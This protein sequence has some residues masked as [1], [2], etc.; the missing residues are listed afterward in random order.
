MMC[1]KVEAKVTHRCES[2]AERIYDAWLNPEKARH[3]LNAALTELGLAAEIRRIEIDARVGGSFFFSDMRDG[4]EAKHWGTYLELD[5]PR[6]IVFTWITDEKKEDEPSKVTLSL[7]PDGQGCIA[8]IVHELDAK[9]A[10]YIPQ[11]QKGWSS[12]LSAIDALLG[13]SN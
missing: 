6:K 1:A 4:T 3:W 9:W 10:E 11:T 5:R 12:F 8:T 2:S 13:A 7:E